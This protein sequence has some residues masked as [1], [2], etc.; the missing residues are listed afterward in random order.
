MAATLT[1]TQTTIGKKAIMALTGFIL[2][3]FVIAHMV[4][5][6]KVFTGES[7]FNE[8]AEFLRVVGEPALPYS[9]LLWI[10]R[11]VLLAA[12]GLHIWAA[13][14][15]TLLDRASRPVQY[16]QKKALRGNFAS[17]TLRYGGAAIFFFILFHLAHLTLGWAHPN[18]ASWAGHE[19]A[20]HNVIVAFQNPISVVIYA[21]ALAALGMH[22]FHG[23][24]SM[25][26][27]LGLNSARWDRPLRAL[28]ALSG[29]GLFV[30]FLSVPIAVMLGLVK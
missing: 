2:Y 22:L 6:L 29:I 18:A 1:L 8:Y 23:V 14:S 20:Y 13:V 17:M 16:R 15:L 30:G 12:V 24:W 27:T 26:Q 4:G 9:T 19:D 25:F 28:A 3:G 11:I 10:F 21:I 5:N 7:H